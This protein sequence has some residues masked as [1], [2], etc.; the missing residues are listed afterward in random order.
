MR[1][2]RPRRPA[3]NG[4]RAN[5][6]ERLLDDFT[7]AAAGVIHVGKKI[8]CADRRIRENENR[9]DEVVILKIRRRLAAVN[10]LA[11]SKRAAMKSAAAQFHSFAGEG[12][13]LVEHRCSPVSG[14]AGIWTPPWDDVKGRRPC[15]RPNDSCYSRASSLPCPSY[16]GL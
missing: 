15:R 16:G 5:I 7:A 10:E 9:I 14:Y 8:Q 6:F 13:V 2:H 4:A 11:I 12:L 1:R 3:V